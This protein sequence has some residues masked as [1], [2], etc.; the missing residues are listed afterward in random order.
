[1]R[2]FLSTSAHHGKLPKNVSS[3]PDQFSINSNEY[4]CGS[5]GQC[6]V[7]GVCV[8][9]GQREMV[10]IYAWC[11]IFALKQD[12]VTLNSPEEDEIVWLVWLT[13]TAGW[14]G[15]ILSWLL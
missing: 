8:W 14:L 11:I 5:V 2:F 12:T 6:L 9:L 15:K 13:A 1:L 7:P 10:A 4:D 3:I